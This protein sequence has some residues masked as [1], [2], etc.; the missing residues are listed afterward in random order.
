VLVMKPNLP[1]RPISSFLNRKS[2]GRKHPSPPKY[3]VGYKFNGAQI[4]GYIGWKP[5]PSRHARNVHFYRLKCHCGK[6][7]ER[8]QDTLHSA[9]RGAYRVTCGCHQ[10]ELIEAPAAYTPAVPCIH[11]WGY[12]PR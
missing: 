4:V 3:S 1:D 6:E 11:N 12:N 5:H 9:T 10:K 8:N 2:A 7:F